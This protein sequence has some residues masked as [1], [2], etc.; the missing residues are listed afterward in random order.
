[1]ET[2]LRVHVVMGVSLVW[3]E[4]ATG[5]PSY[6]L[7]GT[8]PTYANSI[9]YRFMRMT[10]KARTVASTLVGCLLRIWLRRSSCFIFLNTS[11]TCHLARYTYSTSAAGQVSDASV[12]M[13]S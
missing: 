7:G 11:S 5:N 2:A 6:H 4:D 10:S 9:G 12:V 3:C 1:M 8:S 13:R